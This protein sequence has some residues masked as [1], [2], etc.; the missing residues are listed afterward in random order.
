MV[1]IWVYFLHESC[2]S[3]SQL[4]TGK[5]L[6]HLDLPRLS[7]GHLC[8]YYLFGHFCTGQCIL[9]W[10][11]PNCSLSYG[12]FLGMIPKWKMCHFVSSFIPNQLHTN[13][14]GKFSFLVPKRDLGQVARIWILTNPNC[15]LV[16]SIQTHH[17]WFQM[18]I[19]NLN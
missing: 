7:Y 8:N 6:G 16:L 11:W 15:T 9:I 19:S 2:S 18:T 5:N 12:Y 17:K 10:I 13:W 4:S 3:M 1:K 14:V